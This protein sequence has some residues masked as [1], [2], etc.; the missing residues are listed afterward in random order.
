MQAWDPA[1]PAARAALADGLARLTRVCEHGTQ[2][3]FEELLVT[4]LTPLGEDAER[5]GELCARVFGGLV[6]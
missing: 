4:A 3:E 5:Y 2:A 1:A 6:R